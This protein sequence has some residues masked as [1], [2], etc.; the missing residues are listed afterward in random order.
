[1][2]PTN[3][4]DKLREILDGLIDISRSWVDDQLSGTS[5]YVEAMDGLDTELQTAMT[6]ITALITEAER[7]AK[8][9]ALKD[10]R[11]YMDTTSQNYFDAI[12]TVL[13][14]RI[15]DLEATLS[16]TEKDVK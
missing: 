5:Y 4:A 3:N 15:E 6:A 7:L 10:F 8:L 16:A 2:T 9:T 1:M 11:H 12:Y 14:K 13:V